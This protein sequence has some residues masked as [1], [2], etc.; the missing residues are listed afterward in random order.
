ME[1]IGGKNEKIQTKAQKRI[2]ACDH[3]YLCNAHGISRFSASEPLL[4]E[5]KLHENKMKSYQ[6][7]NKNDSNVQVNLLHIHIVITQTWFFKG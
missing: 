1:E 2:K 6:F 3:R 7:E 5:R 4:K